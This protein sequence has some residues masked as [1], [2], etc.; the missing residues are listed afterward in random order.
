MEHEQIG[1][2]TL[3][4]GD[5]REVL[6]TLEAV[7]SVITDPPYGTGWVVGGGKRAGTFYACGQSASWDTWDLGWLALVHADI[8]AVFCPVGQL[9]T[10]LQKHPAR[11]RYYIKSNP[12]PAGPHQD[13]PSVEPI[14]IW[15]RLFQS[16]GLQH[17]IAYNDDNMHPCQKPLMV[18]AWL[19][20]DV[21][22]PGATVLD[23]FM[24]SGTTGVACLQLGRSFVG[25]ERDPRYFDLACQRLTDAY[26]Q[27]DL[28]VPTPVRPE[29]QALFAGG[30]HALR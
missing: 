28:F 29:Q 30:R 25:V 17:C 13:R 27:P 16:N 14:V 11:L 12:R 6:P 21:S 4:R 15:P 22:A 20:R 3:Y 19:V 18:L 5:C 26:A 23:P 1:A 24:G 7:G 2:C 10:L 8:Y 9:S